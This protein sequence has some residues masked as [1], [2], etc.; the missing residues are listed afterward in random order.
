[1][2][3]V[4]HWQVVPTVRLR[5]QCITV[6]RFSITSYRHKQLVLSSTLAVHLDKQAHL[7]Q[8]KPSS[9]SSASVLTRGKVYKVQVELTLYL[10]PHLML[11]SL[12]KEVVHCPKLQVS[13]LSEL[14]FWYFLHVV[15]LAAPHSPQLTAAARACGLVS[16]ISRR[17]LC[18]S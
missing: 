6:G 1:V 8:S 4:G 9:S 17:R 13:L 5:R 7:Y 10:Y 3:N 16:T 14:H 15:Q 12:R 18:C 2:H 11:M